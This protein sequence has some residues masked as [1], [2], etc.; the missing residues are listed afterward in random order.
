MDPPLTAAEALRDLLTGSRCAGCGRPGRLLCRACAAG[1]PQVAVPAWPDPVPPGLAPPWAAAAYEG[2]VRELVVGHKER[3][4]LAH[5]PPLA[6][7]L[8]LAVGAAAPGPD[9]VLILPVPSRR[10]VVRARGHDPLGTLARLA[11]RRLRRDGVAARAVPGVLAVRGP[12]LDQA[13]LGAAARAA[14]LAGSQWAPGLRRLA[15]AP[16]GTRLVV[17]DDVVT[18]G[19]TLAEAQRALAAVGVAVTGHAL[20]AATPRRRPGP[21]PPPSPRH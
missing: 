7:L 19:S 9:P 10:A 20:V 1:L 5:A 11:A 17:V 3:R 14:N 15:G 13:G 8:A 2:T 12:V 18:T 6:A 21:L 16:P 4:R